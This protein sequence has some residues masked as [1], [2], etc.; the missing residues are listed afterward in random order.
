MCTP[1]TP[2]EK[3]LVIAV[4][5]LLVVLIALVVTIIVVATR[6]VDSQQMGRIIKALTPKF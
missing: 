3:R 6:N 2:L 1:K 5:I 4:V